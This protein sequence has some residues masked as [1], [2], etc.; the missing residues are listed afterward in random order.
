MSKFSIQRFTQTVTI[1]AEGTTETDTSTRELNGLI[2]GIGAVVPSLV[3]TTTLTLTLKDASGITLWTK[4]S[5]AEGAAFGEYID[6]NNF[7]LQ[8][9][10]SG[11]VSITVTASNA[12][13]GAAAPI[14]VVLYIQRGN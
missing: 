5:I 2:R 8:I 14:P 9:P 7:P 4:S 3:G 6:A 11:F 12:Q 13:T 10:V 1:L